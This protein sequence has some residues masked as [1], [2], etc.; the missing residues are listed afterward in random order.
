M[1]F[2]PTPYPSLL[3]AIGYRQLVLVRVLRASGRSARMFQKVAGN[4]I[5]ARRKAGESGAENGVFSEVFQ[6]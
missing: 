2:L 3:L 1:D 6:Y 5:K 4:A